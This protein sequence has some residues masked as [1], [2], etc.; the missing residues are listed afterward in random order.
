VL[1]NTG[2]GFL[3]EHY[4]LSLAVPNELLDSFTAMIAKQE[5][6]K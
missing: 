4:Q 1:R 3:I 5:K 6:K 2:K